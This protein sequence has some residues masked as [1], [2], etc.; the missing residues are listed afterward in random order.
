[1]STPPFAPFAPTRSDRAAL[2]FVQLGAVAVVLAALPYKTFDLDRYFV[3]KEL[4]LHLTAALAALML[5]RGVRRVE[6][7][8]VDVLL[9]GLLAVSVASTLFAINY[10]LAE[11]ALLITVSGATLFW[12]A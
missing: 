6:L 5:L 1:M 10:W 12:V 8:T 9:A 3:P 7:T 2:L 4:A 11:R